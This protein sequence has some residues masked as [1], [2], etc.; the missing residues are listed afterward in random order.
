MA[1]AAGPSCAELGHLEGVG[2]AVCPEL[3]GP[4]DVLGASFSADARAN[5][6]VRTFVQAAKDMAAVS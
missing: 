2:E 1:S 3:A 6:K 4:G 5:A